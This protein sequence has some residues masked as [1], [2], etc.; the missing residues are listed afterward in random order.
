MYSYLQQ[1]QVVPTFN[2]SSQFVC[3][4]TAQNTSTEDY[5]RWVDNTNDDFFYTLQPPLMACPSSPWADIGSKI[6]HCSR[7][8]LKKVHYNQSGI[9]ENGS[10]EF[11]KTKLKASKSLPGSLP[12]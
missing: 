5:L 1:D 3:E 9:D 12:S 7:K 8:S 6:R 4:E 10:E 2:P 11:V